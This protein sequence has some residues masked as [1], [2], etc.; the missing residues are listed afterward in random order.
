M[1]TTKFKLASLLMLCFIF[2]STTGYSQFNVPAN[3]GTIQEAVDAA[4]IA[5]GGTV[6][7]EEGVYFENIIIYN[8]VFVISVGQNTESV[9]IDTEGTDDIVIFEECINGGIIGFTLQ[10]GGDNGQFSGIKITGDQAPVIAKNII[11]NANQ[12]MVSG[13]NAVSIV[14]AACESGGWGKADS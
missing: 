11:I 9:I 5:E 6:Y 13:G 2:I 4:Y 12:A 10:N 1:K 14:L 3:Y 7:V 8:N